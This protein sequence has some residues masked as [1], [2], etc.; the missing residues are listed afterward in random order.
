MRLEILAEVMGFS[1]DCRSRY[2]GWS[3]AKDSPLRDLLCRIYREQTGKEMELQAV[4]AGL[5]CGILLSKVP[6]LDIVAIGPDAEG[7]HSPDERVN[8]AS[9]ERTWNFV[10]AIIE[11]C[12]E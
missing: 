7:A 10:R 6:G 2:P 1:F 8:I 12:A 9:A 11:H 5:E 4:H 3:F